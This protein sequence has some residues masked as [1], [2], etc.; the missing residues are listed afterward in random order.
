MASEHTDCSR[1]AGP[2]NPT[3][4]LAL[5]IRALVSPPA[6]TSLSVLGCGCEDQ[7]TSLERALL[8][9]VQAQ[10]GKVTLG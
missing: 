10:E 3:A 9:C 6:E 2:E 1:P 8:G 5:E 4:L 7:V